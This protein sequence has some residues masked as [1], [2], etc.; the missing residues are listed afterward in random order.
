VLKI[1]LTKSMRR[2]EIMLTERK[3]RAFLL[4]GEAIDFTLVHQYIWID[5]SKISWLRNNRWYL[6]RG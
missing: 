4:W 5:R 6:R 1:K 2:L 3:V